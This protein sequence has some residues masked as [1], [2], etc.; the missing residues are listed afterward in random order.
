LWL[1]A[2]SSHSLVEPIF[3]NLNYTSSQDKHLFKPTNSLHAQAN[4]NNP[5]VVVSCLT[6]VIDYGKDLAHDGLKLKDPSLHKEH[7]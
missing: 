2:Q 5:N 6:I 1:L 7:M 3:A 4:D